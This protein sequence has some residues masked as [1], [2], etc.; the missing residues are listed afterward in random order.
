MRF[1]TVILMLA[2]AMPSYAGDYTAESTVRVRT[3]DHSN[4]ELGLI[5][6][7]DGHRNKNG[8]EGDLQFTGSTSFGYLD[9]GANDLGYG[10]GGVYLGMNL[11]RYVAIKGKM[12]TLTHRQ[13]FIKSTIFVN[14]VATNTA[15]DL[16]LTTVR[17]NAQAPNLFSFKRVEGDLRAAFTC[18]TTMDRKITGSYWQER[19]YGDT[20]ARYYSMSLNQ[21]FIDRTTKEWGAGINSAIGEGAVAVGFNQRRF[22]DH[23]QLVQDDQS[24]EVTPNP[25]PLIGNVTPKVYARIHGP[26]QKMDLYSAM[27]RSGAD[28]V[29]PM[30]VSLSERVRRSEYNGYVSNTHS[31]TLGAAYKPTKKSSLNARVYA[32]TT[33]VYED[34]T[35]RDDRGRYWWGSDLEPS[36]DRYNLSG[37]ITGRYEYSQKL[38]FKAGV[39][40]ENNYRRHTPDASFEAGRASWFS[41]GTYFPLG[42]H[43][44]TTASQ[45]TR[46]TYNAGVDASLPYDAELGAGYSKMLA[47]RA[48]YNGLA[49]DED[50]V[51]ATLTVPL[52]HKLTFAGSVGYSAEK[53]KGNWHMINRHM[54]QKTYQAALEWAGTKLP[55]SS[56]ISAGTD[57][58][59]ERNTTRADQYYGF[60]KAPVDNAVHLTQAVYRNTNNTVGYHAT[61]ELPKGF[62][63][64]G[65][66]SYTIAQG[67]RPSI[68][69]PTEN[70]R[71]TPTDI[72]IAR[73]SV[74]LKY[75]PARYKYLSS[76]L[77]YRRDI[78]IDKYSAWENGWVKVVD[79]EVS[80]KF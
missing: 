31:G 9:L 43:N 49:D 33:G 18:P 46:Y 12:T 72:R 37:D 60:D 21:A 79:L 23:A 25:Y 53:N 48:V 51:D 73:D 59:Y 26:T 41:D 36:I 61:L 54:R 52:P 56:E 80:A 30:T 35:F 42:Y 39:K 70:I 32:R 10:E 15:S 11:G 69:S 62:S 38:S 19:E 78:W 55:Y 74:R 77:G 76:S 2:A 16:P 20:P 4:G 1:L 45:D 13:P 28:A 3:M 66:G 7:Y 50:K 68:L 29:V 71:N 34:T 65:Q 24:K 8:V 22:E 63:L 67:E 47:N 27:Y 14:S 57:Y 58:T 40:Y 64:T 44:G 5:Q 17:N 6:E 75:L